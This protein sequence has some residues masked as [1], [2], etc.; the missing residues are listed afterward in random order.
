M[1]CIL[2]NCKE[3]DLLPAHC[4]VKIVFPYSQKGKR[5]VCDP[6]WS[7]RQLSDAQRQVI[8]L[9][10]PAIPFHKATKVTLKHKCSSCPV[11]LSCSSSYHLC[12]SF[13]SG[14]GHISVQFTNRDGSTPERSEE[15]GA[16]SQWSSGGHRRSHQRREK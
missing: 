6:F 1:L 16:A 13:P 5:Q 12:V 10:K 7:R 11:V 8:F 2:F 3:T 15:G 9:Q 14:S 4:T